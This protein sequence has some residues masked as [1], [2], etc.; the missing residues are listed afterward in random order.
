[1]NSSR[2]MLDK[3]V[4]VSSGPELSSQ[5]TISPSSILNIVNRTAMNQKNRDNPF[6]Y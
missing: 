6:K 4:P 1:M 5:E 3:P 2:M